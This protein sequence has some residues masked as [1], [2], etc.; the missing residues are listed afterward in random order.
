MHEWNTA[1]DVK[2]DFCHTIGADHSGFD[3]DDKP[4]KNVAR[5]MVNMLEDMK[6]RERPLRAKGTCFMCH[7]GH[8]EPSMHADGEGGRPG[9]PG[10]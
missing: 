1:L 3:K 7:H 5:S 9:G 4:M 2:C 6:K 10:R 8:A